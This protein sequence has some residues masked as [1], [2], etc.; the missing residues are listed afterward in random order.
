MSTELVDA[1]P[2]EL[3]ADLVAMRMENETIMAA[4]AERPRDMVQIKT[5]L[6]EQFT[7]F[8]ESAEMSIYSKPVGKDPQ[9]GKMKFA[10]GLSIRAAETLA[11][12]YGFNRVRCDVTPI[13][14]DHVKV[15]ATFTDFQRGRIWQDAGIVSKIYQTRTRGMQRHNDDRFYNV[16]VRAEGSKRVREVIMRCIS[17]ALKAWYFD[18]CKKTMAKLLTDEKLAGIVAYFD[19]LGC[20][21]EQ[22]E[23]IVGRPKTMGWTVSDRSRLLS[24][25]N[26]LKEN[27]T[28]L[29]EVLDEASAKTS[30]SDIDAQLA[31]DI[32]KS[33]VETVEKP[34]PPPNRQTRD[35]DPIA[36]DEPTITSD[37]T[38]EAR[39]ESLGPN[40]VVASPP[41]NPVE[42]PKGFVDMLATSTSPKQ[43]EQV[44]EFW[45]KRS[46]EFEL[47]V[48]E[49]MEAAMVAKVEAIRNKTRGG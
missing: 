44:R 42:L 2:I 40:E 35:G 7:L 14:D 20:T 1:P 13:D 43:I 30:I 47:I 49:A 10:E 29:A 21:L 48:W 15:E 36:R 8:P 46:T 23:T 3:R 38:P 25:S 9:T 34:S 18:E 39:S 4:C 41:D 11:E 22:L 16:V 19:K 37:E 32:P 12:L 24:I 27:E 31:D 5:D 45:V 6:L 33:Q 26:A 17:G 28:T